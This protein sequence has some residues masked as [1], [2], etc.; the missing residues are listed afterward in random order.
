[1]KREIEFPVHAVTTTGINPNPK[2][3]RAIV[4]V[5]IPNAHKEIK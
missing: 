2:K 3:V 5:P 1:M 4:N